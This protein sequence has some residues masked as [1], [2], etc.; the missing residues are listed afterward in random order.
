MHGEISL[1]RQEKCFPCQQF[2]AKKSTFSLSFLLS[3]VLFCK[4]D[5]VMHLHVNCLFHFL[6]PFS[7]QRNKYHANLYNAP[8][9]NQLQPSANE[10]I[11]HQE[12]RIVIRN[13]YKVHIHH[14]IDIIT[15]C[16]NVGI[17]QYMLAK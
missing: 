13:T 15:S 8:A 3:I 12:I 4:T 2:T 10:N 11:V 17:D 1:Y 5:R 16:P 6:P 9:Y 7:Q 14:Y